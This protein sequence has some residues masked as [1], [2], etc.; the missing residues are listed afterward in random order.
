MS[1]PNTDIPIDAKINK[2]AK[3]GKANCMMR[4]MLAS[5][6]EIKSDIPG[7]SK[8]TSNNRSDANRQ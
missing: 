5:K 6:V 8:I 2:N 1:R 4:F 3:K 7:M